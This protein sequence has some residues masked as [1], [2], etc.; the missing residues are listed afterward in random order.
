ML[1]IKKCFKKKKPLESSPGGD[2]R[3]M[4]RDTETTL[5]YGKTAG[6]CTLPTPVS[7]ERSG[8]LLIQVDSTW[9]HYLFFL[10][11][12]WIWRPLKLKIITSLRHIRK[13]SPRK[14]WWSHVGRQENI[15]K[16]RKRSTNR[17][18]S[19]LQSPPARGL[20]IPHSFYSALHA[21][22]IFHLSMES[23]LSL[24]FLYFPLMFQPL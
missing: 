19:R 5:R 14:H 11:M 12:C 23:S 6:L 2:C 20:S 22:N 3:E 15:G 21:F 17:N 9:E 24:P 13:I 18:R 7:T 16:R 8:N 4:W 10:V 1:H